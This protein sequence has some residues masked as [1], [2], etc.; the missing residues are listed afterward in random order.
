M[1]FELM[2]LMDIKQNQIRLDIILKQH[3]LHS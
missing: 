1:M 3:E 2:M